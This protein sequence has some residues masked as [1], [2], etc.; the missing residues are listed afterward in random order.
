MNP[1]LL[2]VRREI[3]EKLRSRAFLIVNLILLVIVVAGTVL[4][5]LLADDEPDPF[6][7]AAVGS[8]AVEVLD[9]AADQAEVFGLPLEVTVVD[10]VATGREL[11]L[12]GDVAAV[13]DG[14]DALVTTARLTGDRLELLDSARRIQRLDRALADA[15]VDQQERAEVLTAPRLDVT[16]LEADGT[17]ADS[18]SPVSL[19]VGLGTTFVLYG[20]LIFYGQQIAQGIVQEKQSRVIEVL[21]AAVR[22]VHLL[23]GKVLGLGL[24]GLAQITVMAVVGSVG[25]QLTGSVEVPPGTTGAL[26]STLPWFVLGYALY[27]MVF[28]MTAALVPKI[29]D[30][31]TAMTLPIL[32]LVGSLFLSQFAIQDPD[33]TLATVG[34]LVPFS[35]PIVHP[36]LAALGE[37]RPVLTVLGV[38]STLA[39]TA[40]LVPVAARVHAGASLS[41][42]SR[43]KVREALRR[44]DS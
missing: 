10:D 43:V 17:A 35:A 37:S 30:L 13:L 36:L 1:L 40:V 26:A 3:A 21:L 20:L 5:G 44:A 25:L 19:A 12:E 23:G 16:V 7:V 27:A 38:V 39:T 22:P 34:A 42:R 29:E 15:G 18:P 41:V 28:A 11:L 9:R 14:A 32:L 4:P 8:E 33:G 2:I 31:Q 6:A 24:L